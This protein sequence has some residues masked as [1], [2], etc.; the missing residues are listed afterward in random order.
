M[1]ELYFR[2]LMYTHENFAADVLQNFEF[3][4]SEY[5]MRR[6]P[7]H[8]AGAGSWVVYANLNVKVVIEYEVGG[9]CGVSVV[10]LRHVKHDPLERSE[11]DLEEIIAVA[12]PRQQRRQDPR[13]MSEAVAKS[14]ETL[15]SIGASVLKGDFEALHTRQRGRVEA[16]RRHNPLTN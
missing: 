6:E 3:L 12:A 2:A 10:N 4:E 7:T 9:S 11:F 16:L 8:V 5:G 1:R 13:S 14:A 15:R